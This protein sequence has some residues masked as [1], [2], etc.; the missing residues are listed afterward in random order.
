MLTLGSRVRL[1]PG[2]RLQYDAVRERWVLL[3]PE[4][5]LVLD[6]IARTILERCNGQQVSALCDTLAADF[7]APL[8]MIRSDVLV[9]LAS[10]N[11]KGFLRYE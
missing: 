10:M 9:L 11:M 7:D 6:D 3:A 5:M 2:T 1:A 8:A 4:R